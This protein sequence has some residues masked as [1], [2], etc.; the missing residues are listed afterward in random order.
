MNT[1]TDRSM[2]LDHHRH[3]LETLIG[4]SDYVTAYHPKQLG[5]RFNQVIDGVMNWLTAGSMPRISKRI[6][7]E[8][9]VWKVYDPATH[10]T[11]YFDQEG[12]LRIWLE[13][14]YYQ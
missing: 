10:R 6:H 14:R 7:G 13:E 8:A 11:L 12:A 1:Y 9:E 2:R 4:N 5:T 3:H